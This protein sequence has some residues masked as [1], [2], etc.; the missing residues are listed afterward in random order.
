LAIALIALPE[1]EDVR[2]ASLAHTL[3]SKLQHKAPNVTDFMKIVLVCI[4]IR[5]MLNYGFL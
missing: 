1:L 4:E 2:A 3:S 5:R